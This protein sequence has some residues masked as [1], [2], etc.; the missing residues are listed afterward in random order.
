MDV[1]QQKIVTCNLLRSN[2]IFTFVLSYISV[3]FTY[4]NH[5]HFPI[6]QNW[7]LQGLNSAAAVGELNPFLPITHEHLS[8]LSK[9]FFIS[10]DAVIEPRIFATSALAVRRSLNIHYSDR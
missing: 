7:H 6:C 1:C 9:V 2:N 4:H 3:E 8:Y 5:P 10:E